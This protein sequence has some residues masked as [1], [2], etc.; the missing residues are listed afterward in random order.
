MELGRDRE[1]VRG[2]RTAGVVDEN[3]E[4]PERV[5]GGIDDLLG[6]IK[7]SIQRCGKIGTGEMLFKINFE[8]VESWT[9]S[10]SASRRNAQIMAK[11]A[12][13]IEVELLA[14][15]LAVNTLDYLLDTLGNL[16]NK[17]R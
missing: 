11:K 4:A 15:C 8:Y 12:G 13:C 16:E 5:L 14:L 1:R 10:A 2:R 3:V 6:Y 9:W 7:S 17:L